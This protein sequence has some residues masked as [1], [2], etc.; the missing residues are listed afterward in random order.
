[1]KKQKKDK[2]DDHA[3]D[4]NGNDPDDGSTQDEED[5]ADDPHHVHEFL[6]WTTGIEFGKCLE[7]LGSNLSL[8][9]NLNTKQT[10][11]AEYHFAHGQLGHDEFG[12]IAL[13]TK[14]FMDVTS[15]S[16][17]FIYYPPRT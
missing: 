13:A 15:F 10:R 17:H 7:Q 8:N 11:D 4:H 1:M 2:V 14:G 16:F 3:N 12:Y 5:D 9:W 6:R